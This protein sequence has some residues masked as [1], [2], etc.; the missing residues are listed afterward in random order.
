MSPRSPLRPGRLLVV[1]AIS[2]LV[3]LLIEHFGW[4]EFEAPRQDGDGAARAQQLQL[5]LRLVFI[6]LIPVGAYVGYQ[7]LQIIR[8]RHFPPPGSR[9]LRKLP[10]HSGSLASVRGWL[11]L[12]AGLCLCGLGVYGAFIVPRE[13]ARLFYAQ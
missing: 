8:H 13:I 3:F 6:P 7:G 11:A 10:P 1:L 12:C 2:L 4:L 9:L 5:L